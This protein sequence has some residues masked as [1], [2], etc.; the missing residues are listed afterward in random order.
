MEFSC[1]IVRIFYFIFSNI[2]KK[3]KNF[4]R[5]KKVDKGFS[6]LF[7][8]FT[9][10]IPSEHR[11]STLYLKLSLKSQYCWIH[12]LLFCS[13]HYLD[14]SRPSWFLLPC[15]FTLSFWF[16]LPPADC[17]HPGIPG[18]QTQGRF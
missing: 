14:L 1:Q 18:V 10:N 8:H 4:Q 3:K 6:K 13:W 15:L 7:L 2:C 9:L 12:L 16:L 5:T 17:P 11:S